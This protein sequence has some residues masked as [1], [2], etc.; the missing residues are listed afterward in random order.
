MDHR[1]ASRLSPPIGTGLRA[2]VLFLAVVAGCDRNGQNSAATPSGAGTAATAAPP[3]LDL[4]G[5]TLLINGHSISYP[6]NISPDGQHVALVRS[7]TVDGRTVTWCEVDGRPGPDAESVL[8]GQWS[9]DGSTYA[10]R[11]NDNRSV[12]VGGVAFGP[13]RGLSA[14]ALSPSGAHWA[15]F[16][17]APP[18]PRNSNAVVLPTLIVDGRPTPLPPRYQFGAP[19]ETLAFTARDP[20]TNDVHWFAVAGGGPVA[21]PTAG[22]PATKPGGVPAVLT[23]QSGGTAV[24]S[25]VAGYELLGLR[26][27]RQQLV[28]NGTPAG[29]YD[30]IYGRNDGGRFKPG[31][32]RPDGTTIVY[33]AAND[34]LYR[35][36]I[37]PIAPPPPSH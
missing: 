22:P 6:V 23:T 33:A 29:T 15:T 16:E 1:A 34:K 32:V 35:L 37:P 17:G 8:P 27:V 21:A 9:L 3:V 11:I 7:R 10:Y 18:P 26:Y 4:D 5:V 30:A 25:N 36:A 12:V 19:G 2:T 24:K 13:Y 28:V 20:R 31:T 14:I